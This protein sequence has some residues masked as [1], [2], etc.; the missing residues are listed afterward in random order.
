MWNVDH[1][2]YCR[3]MHEAGWIASVFKTIPY[4]TRSYLAR[5][6]F[7][8]HEHILQALILGTDHPLFSYNFN[9][10]SHGHE[11]SHDPL[12]DRVLCRRFKP[13]TGY[14]RRY[15]DYP[16]GHYRLSWHRHYY[17]QSTWYP[18]LMLWGWIPHILLRN[19]A[20]KV[21]L[22]LAAVISALMSFIW[23]KFWLTGCS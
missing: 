16:K 17:L 22:N 11:A 20:M 19:A 1:T 2:S 4:A 5:P 10:V 9:H 15:L 21:R 14:Q 18:V 23:L 6:A 7:N 3:A 12:Y 8:Y 13:W